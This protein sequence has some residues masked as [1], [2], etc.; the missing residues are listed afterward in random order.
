MPKPWPM[1]ITLAG[2]EHLEKMEEIVRQ[3]IVACGARR[4]SVVCHYYA[5]ADDW[6]LRQAMEKLDPLDRAGLH[7]LIQE[8][9]PKGLRREAGPEDWGGLYGRL[10]STDGMILLAG[11]GWELLSLFFFALSTHANNGLSPDN[12]LPR[13]IAYLVPEGCD[14]DRL[15]GWD[16]FIQ[17]YLD[18]RNKPLCFRPFL[19]KVSTAEDAV[20]WALYEVWPATG[21]NPTQEP[22]DVSVVIHGPD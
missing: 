1:H 6:R 17:E 13:R 20:K 2:G 18:I 7:Q 8:Q 12:R 9:L 19:V 10:A 4:N 22:N 3:I 21:A 11:L 14:P 16:R 15:S 5:G